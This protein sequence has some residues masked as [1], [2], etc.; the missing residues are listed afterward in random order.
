MSE[1]CAWRIAGLHLCALHKSRVQP[2]IAFVAVADGATFGPYSP[3]DRTSGSWPCPFPLGRLGTDPRTARSHPRSRQFVAGHHIGPG[4]PLAGPALFLAAFGAFLA[5]PG[6][7]PVLR[8]SRALP[9]D[10]LPRNP[11]MRYADNAGPG[12]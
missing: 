3:D 4:L 5:A 6:A 1:L 8:Q 9:R 2:L 10:P 11:L 12:L 7:V